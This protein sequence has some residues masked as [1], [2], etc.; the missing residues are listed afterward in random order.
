MLPF[1]SLS[2]THIIPAN[3]A[4]MVLELCL[5]GALQKIVRRH[6]AGHGSGR[7]F[8]FQVTGDSGTDKGRT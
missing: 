4:D 6:R 8:A 7:F 3:D 1:Y 5:W 2:L